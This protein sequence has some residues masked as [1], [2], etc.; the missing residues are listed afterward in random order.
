MADDAFVLDA[1]D[2]FVTDLSFAQQSMWLLHQMDPGKPTYNVIAATRIRGPLKSDAL[3]SALNTVVDRHETLRTVFRLEGDMPVQVIARSAQLPLPVTDVHP[4]EVDAAVQREV[5]APLDLERGP[6]VRMRL[7]RLSAEDH[8]LVLV[9]HHIVTD[10]WSSAIVFRELSHYYQSYAGGQAVDLPEPPIQYADY[11]AWQR[12]TLSG[13]RLERLLKYWTQRLAGADQLQLPADRPRPAVRSNRGETLRFGLSDEL[14]SAVEALGRQRRATPFMVLLAAFQALLSRLSGQTDITVATAVANR[15]RPEVVGLIGYFVNTLALRMD[16]SGN[17]TVAEL[18]DR[19][20]DTCREAYG[21][22]ELPFDKVVEVVQP[23]RDGGVGNALVR[24]MLILQNLPTEPWRSGELVFEPMSLDNRTSMLDLSVTIEAVPAGGYVCM[25]EYSADLFDRSTI[26][27]FAEAYIQMLEAFVADPGALVE[28][29]DL[30]GEGEWARMVARWNATDRELPDRLVHELVA[31][32]AARTPAA[33]AVE[34]GEAR[35]TYADLDELA[36]RLACALRA[37]AT[38]EESLI[39]IALTP[40][41]ELAV[42]VLAALRSGRAFLPLDPHLPPARLAETLRDAGVALVLTERHLE[43]K[44]TAAADGARVICLDQGWRAAGEASQDRARRPHRDSLACVFYTSGSTN[45]PKGVMFTH[46]AL[47][48]FTLAFAD[49][50]ELSAGDRFLQLS[51]IGFDVVL[52]ELLLAWVVGATVVLPTERIL[53]TGG[54]LTAY[55]ERHRVTVLDLTPAYWHEWVRLLAGRGGAPETLRLVVVGGDRVLRDC[56]DTW[57]AFGVDLV[58]GYGLTEATVAST[59]CCLRE[60]G[61]GARG[62]GAVI[63]APLANTRLYVLDHRLRPVPAGATGEVY[64][65]GAGLARGY[66]HRPGETAQRF[67]ADPFAGPGARMLRTGDL[68]RR[69]ADAEIELL[70]RVD[71]QLKIRG[72]R[73][74]PGEI[75]AALARHPAVAR[76]AVVTRDDGGGKRLVAYVAG[77]DGAALDPAEVRDRLAQRLPDFMVPAAVVALPSLPMTSSGKLDRQALLAH[78]LAAPSTARGPA[79]PLEERLCGLIAEV[80]GQERVGADDD[81][82]AL[83]GDSIRAIQLAAR[84]RAAGVVISP[85]DVFIRRTPARLAVVAEDPDTAALRDPG[86]GIGPIRPTPG[87]R[88]LAELGGKIDGFSQA[89]LLRVPA[90]LRQACLVEATQALLDHHDAL[91]MTLAVGADGRWEPEVAPKGAVRAPAVVS[92]VEVAGLDERRLREVVAERARAARG[93][94]DPGAGATC[95]VVWFDAGDAQGRLLVVLHHLVVD[96]VSWRILLPDLAVAYQAI[97]DGKPA[98][99]A[100]VGTSFREWALGLSVA[101]AEPVR[102]GELRFWRE[103]VRTPDPL[104]G[105]RTLRPERDVAGTARSLTS[106]LPPEV[107]GPLLSSVPVAFRAGANDVLLTG[108]ALAVG[109]WRGRRGH[110]G[111]AVVVALEGHGR[112]EPTVP[113]A[114]LSRTVG[115]FTSAFPV[116]LDPG[117]VPWEAVRAAGPGVGTA[118]RRVKDQL[119]AV[120]G[121]GI[122]FGLLRYLNPDTAAI[123]A[124]SPTPQIGFNYLGRFGA[125]AA[126]E[127]LGWSL[128]PDTIT[129]GSGLDP[130]M[131]LPHVLE[132]NAVAEERSGSLTLSVTW[133]WAAL[134]LSEADV[135]ELE[136]D[137]F[138]AL[139]ALARQAEKPA[140][141]GLSPSDLPLMSLTQA[142]IDELQAEFGD[143]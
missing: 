8:V 68:A 130:D 116:S 67:V 111:T 44:L 84:A 136:Q 25:T 79:T 40:S 110:R 5:E 65:G 137:W 57:Q 58:E 11:A 9:M 133:L 103:T 1:A 82:F 77:A 27:R 30:A 143:G 20:R 43:S 56:V 83:G 45:L 15:D 24:A 114:E 96:G 128:D 123:L 66:L 47:V 19:A 88:W 36:T 80:L 29:I 86:A 32:R 99:L 6:L 60:R 125:D 17:P 69:R 94:L 115:W 50:L 98:A 31:E 104:L 70:G 90:G 38:G 46:G 74:E 141:G 101:A 75:E 52:E 18:V 81:F 12:E 78:G 28:Q 35:L 105:G 54:D 117:A 23:E 64:I 107:A 93:E 34:H 3:Q 62:P 76:A 73:V 87:F 85:R 119:R 102:A 14:M 127:I 122:G 49:E 100:P 21:H 33:V 26:V 41:A 106:V 108:L 59:T 16:L 120:P 71:D 4:S 92:R 7:L 2:G 131:P 10:G 72:H 39:A 134:V 113:G 61:A 140:S 37:G 53:A 132:I 135:R 55:V 124:A 118:L 22:Q 129:L 126:D 121:G 97:V 48:N 91:R 142:E 112:E 13:P 95:R 51:S 63:G 109:R 42:A 138:T 89:V 139:D